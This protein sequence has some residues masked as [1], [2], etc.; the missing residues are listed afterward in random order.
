MSRAL[1]AQSQKNCSASSPPPSFA[2]TTAYHL[3]RCAEEGWNREEVIDA[4]NVALV[5]GGS[6]TIPHVR[7]A[8]ARMREIDSLKP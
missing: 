1:S 4:L 7:R 6:I 3:V 2:A 5:V 8:F